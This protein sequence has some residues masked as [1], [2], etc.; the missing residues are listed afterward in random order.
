[1]HITGEPS[2]ATRGTLLANRLLAAKA[3]VANLDIP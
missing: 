3:G 2:W 1:M